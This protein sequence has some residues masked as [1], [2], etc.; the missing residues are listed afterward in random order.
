M[1][2]DKNIAYEKFNLIEVKSED[3]KSKNYY[4]EGHIS[5]IDPDSANDIVTEQ[6]QDSIVD[7]I[8]AK[9]I[10][11]DIDHE[12]FRNSDGTMSKR[13]LNKI[14]VAKI[15]ESKRTA[16][17]T[18]VKAM[19]NNDHPLFSNI[20]SSIKNGFLHSFSIAYHVKDFVNKVLNGQQFRLLNQL[21]LRNV[22]ITGNPVNAN[23]TFSISLK[24]RLKKMVEEE[25]TINLEASIAEIKSSIVS[26]SES[27][28]TSNEALVSELKSLS[29][30]KAEKPSEEE[31][32]EDDEKKKKDEAET[33]SLQEKVES[34]ASE[35]ADLKS[36]LSEPV[37]KAAVEQKSTLEVTETVANKGFEAYI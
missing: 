33:K 7:E 16:L 8:E 28:K 18:Y 34:Q 29:E 9:D 12:S 6:G 22:G 24:S 13:D 14:P 21:E 3:G 30:A 35:I 31:E 4:I 25:N 11:M 23:A 36:K 26:L 32:E 10:T 1:V 19:L 27:F 5:T 17:G 2:E 20:L 37:Q 15:I